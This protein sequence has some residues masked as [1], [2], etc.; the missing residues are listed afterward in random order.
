MQGERTEKGIAR[1]ALPS[2]A[3]SS[4]RGRNVNAEL[5]TDWRRTSGGQFGARAGVRIA[6][7]HRRPTEDR[8]QSEHGHRDVRLL[9]PV[10]SAFSA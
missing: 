3:V 2:E 5:R 1:D 4:H 9:S 6:G 8:S 7:G 10:S